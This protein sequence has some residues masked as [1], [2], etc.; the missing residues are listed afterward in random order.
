M[1]TLDQLDRERR[2]LKPTRRAALAK[3]LRR[4]STI[5]VLVAFGLLLTRFV[6]L[7]IEIYRALRE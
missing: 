1:E 5:K 2:Q 7:G 6:Q 3:L 4:T